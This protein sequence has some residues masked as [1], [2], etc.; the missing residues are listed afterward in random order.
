M[1]VVG[2]KRDLKFDNEKTEYL[3]LRCVGERDIHCF[4]AQ[5]RLLRRPHKHS[6]SLVSVIVIYLGFTLVLCAMSFYLSCN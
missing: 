2:L 3:S 4:Y 6:G 1:K 5:C